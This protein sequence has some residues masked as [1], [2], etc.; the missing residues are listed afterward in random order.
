MVGFRSLCRTESVSRRRPV[1]RSSSSRRSGVAVARRG[2]H[3]LVI[4][5]GVVGTKGFGNHKHNELLSF[6]YHCDGVPV[7]VDP[8]S[9]VYTSDFVARNLFRGTSLSQHDYDRWRRAE[10]AQSRMDLS[11]VRKSQ[12]GTS[13][14][15][16][17]RQATRATAAGTR[18]IPGSNRRSFTN[19]TLRSIWGRPL[20][21]SKIFSMVRERTTC[22]WHFHCA[23]GIAVVCASS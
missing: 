2:G 10:R 14:V 1:T 6:E 15:C 11:D 21:E 3:F 20:L 22:C 13:R 4:T 16:P 12:S 5:N 17:R 18:A 19:G 8:G 9:Y 23:P 7:L